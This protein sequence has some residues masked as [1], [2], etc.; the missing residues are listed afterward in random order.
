METFSL[1]SPENKTHNTSNIPLDFTA[2]ESVSQIAFILDGKDN[3]T[4][5]GNT[6]IAGLPNGNHN[7]IVYA[8]DAFG[9]TGASET[10]SFTVEVPFSTMLVVAPVA[11]VAAVGAV[12]AFYFKKRNGKKR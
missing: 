11:S 7:I 2:G 3:V 9:N 8:T 4:V 12:V 1:L 5:I 10:V 6:T